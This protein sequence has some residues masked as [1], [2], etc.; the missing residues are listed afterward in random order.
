[1]RPLGL[2]NAQALPGTEGAYLPFWSPESRALGFFAGGK[3]KKIEL[4]GGP[5]L[6]LCETPLGLGGSWNRDGVI[7]FVPKWG[8]VHRIPDT[9]G[10]PTPVT[11]LDQSRQEQSHLWPSFLP[12]GRHFLYWAALTRSEGVMRVGS[13]ETKESKCLL[14][15]CHY[16]HDI[17]GHRPVRPG[18]VSCQ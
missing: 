17:I 7:V 3:L 10:V 16:S 13:L 15:Y 6:T 5:P 4:S 12:D 11:T 1:V 14:A 18:R 9:G 2:L 8:I